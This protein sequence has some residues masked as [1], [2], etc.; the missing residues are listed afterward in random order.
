MIPSSSHQSRR[1]LDL[2]LMHQWATKTYISFC[3][4]SKPDYPMWQVSLPLEGLKHEFLLNGLLSMAALEIALTRDGAANSKYA[5]A[6]LEYYDT[7]SSTFREE[8]TDI[9][10]EKQEIILAFSLIAIVLSLA[11][12]QLLKA[13]GEKPRMVDHMFVHSELLKGVR[14]IT[15]QHG[16]QIRHAP[17]LRNQ[18]NFEEVPMGP[19]DSGTGAAIARLD[20][21]NDQRHD[22]GA[23]SYPAPHATE[24]AICQKAIRYLEEC[25]ARC[26]EPIHRGHALAWLRLAGE[27]FIEVLKKSNSVALLALMHWGV[28]AERCSEGFWWAQSVGKNLVDEI[29]DLLAHD[30]DSKLASS[31]SWARAEVGLASGVGN[32]VHVLQT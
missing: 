16:G 9:R 8:I 20:A 24:H 4:E 25:F 18:M 2:E 1:L 3:G 17:I 22:L 13:R 26:Q 23:E 11:L 32:N 10:L 28:L 21:L 7:A 5:T 12:P 6:A 31:I 19:L 14:L 29:T 27:D 30:E 15:S